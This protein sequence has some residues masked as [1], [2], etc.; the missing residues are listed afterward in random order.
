MDPLK[1][2]PESDASENK[3]SSEAQAA[4][5]QKQESQEAAAK[6]VSKWA[7]L[8]KNTLVFAALGLILV[9][10][11]CVV[12]I[13]HV[14]HAIRQAGKIIAPL[15]IG[16]VIAYLCNPILEFYE[17][18]ALRRLKNGGLR[19]GLSLTFTVLTAIAFVT[20]LFL[21]IVPKLIESIGDLMSNYQVYVDN[22]ISGTSNFLRSMAEKNDWNIDV[23][24]LETQ[25]R[26]FFG[27]SEN[28]FKKVMEFINKDGVD[29]GGMVGTA[30][31][32]I[33]TIF[34][35]W[36]L[37]IFI[38]FYFLAS[39]EKRV[40]QV[41]K[42]RRAMFNKKQNERI[43]E[44][45][46][47]ADNTFSGYVFGVLIDALVVG[48]MTFVLLSIFKVSPRYNLLISAICA[49]TNIIPVFGPFIGAIPSA[50]IV[51]ISNPS[52]FFL[53]IFLVLVI[54]QIDGNLLCPKIQ[55]D[56]TGISSLAVLVAI[57]IAGSIGGI[58][59]MIIGVP[60]FAVIIELIKRFLEHRLEKKGEPTDTTAYYPKD[61]LGNAEKDV[62]YEH[63]SLRYEYEHSKLK[64]RLDHLKHRFAKKSKSDG[65][66]GKKGKKNN[67]KSTKKNAKKKKKH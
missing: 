39:K 41:N 59:G 23:D 61:A 67:Q 53:F 40:A 30:V 1:N 33:I 51:L 2:T 49:A 64:T 14:A 29:I 12:N 65:K 38:A 21:M 5:H 7:K 4:D 31:M 57:T 34:K 9:T 66:K 62:Y 36:I 37:G 19:R 20:L 8:S 45:V 54:Q 10:A 22:L 15:F 25:M 32:D 55:G 35:D 6:P 27:S 46:H 58:P 28:L 42:F 24:N 52:K 17:Y 44:V 16:A 13:D 11:Y 56:N 26:N 18:R 60:I 43:S 3:P 50:L 48:V 63:A 47:L